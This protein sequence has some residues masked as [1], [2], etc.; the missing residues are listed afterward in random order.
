[1]FLE[2]MGALPGRVGVPQG[3]KGDLHDFR[4]FHR[5]G[6]LGSYKIWQI[7]PVWCWAGGRARGAIPDG[8]DGFVTG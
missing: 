6:L 3:R 7:V 1:M 4:A 8:A 5:R 2:V